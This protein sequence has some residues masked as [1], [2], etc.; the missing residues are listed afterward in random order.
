M[1]IVI[2]NDATYPL[3]HVFDIFLHEH[4]LVHSFD[5]KKSYPLQLEIN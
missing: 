5:Q 4:E 2:I 3:F 1:G